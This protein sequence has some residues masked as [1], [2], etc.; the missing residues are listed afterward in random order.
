MKEVASGRASFSFNVEPQLKP[1]ERE[2]AAFS[3]EINNGSFSWLYNHCSFSVINL[4]P[5][6]DKIN[7]IIERKATG[8]DQTWASR[9][10]RY[11]ASQ[12]LAKVV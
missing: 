8:L 10:A 12:L 2:D 1:M 4:Y 3:W 5:K 9:G 7:N 11:Y 6:A